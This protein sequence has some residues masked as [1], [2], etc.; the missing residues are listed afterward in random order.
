MR[1]VLWGYGGSGREARWRSKNIPKRLDEVA[2]SNIWESDTRF[3]CFSGKIHWFHRLHTYADSTAGSAQNIATG[4][5]FLRHKR[6]HFLIYQ[7][8][9]RPDGMRVYIYAAEI[10]RSHDTMLYSCI[11]GN[12]AYLLLPWLQTAFHWLNATLDCAACLK[13]VYERN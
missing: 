1:G 2:G 11:F 13:H 5:L 6:I 10:R 7:T 8:A 3:W 4:D 9:T 12:A